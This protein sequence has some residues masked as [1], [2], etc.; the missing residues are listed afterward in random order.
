MGCVVLFFVSIWFAEASRETGGRMCLYSGGM[1]QLFPGEPEPRVLHWADV[2]DVVLTTKT[3]S[4]DEPT[5]ELT[6]CAV[7]GKGTQIG[8]GPRVG[9]AVVRAVHRA[10]APRLVPPMIAV[11][12]SGEEV[13]PGRCGSASR[14]S[15]CRPA[16]A[17]PGPT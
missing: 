8:N 12:E 3:D 15:R 4:D 5:R 2:E 10:V 6:W 7:Q 13:T 11:C 17:W 16:G 1:A 9:E 14:R